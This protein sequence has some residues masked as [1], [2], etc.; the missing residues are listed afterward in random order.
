MALSDDGKP[1][2]GGLKMTEVSPLAAESS[3]LGEE[4]A[5]M[6]AEQGFKVFEV[7]APSFSVRRVGDALYA[8]SCLSDSELNFMVA[9]YAARRMVG[10]EPKG[11]NSEERPL[12]SI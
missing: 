11:L 5:K 8:S 4:V 12:P 6:A 2:K 10:L 7:Q 1:Q 9:H 3:R